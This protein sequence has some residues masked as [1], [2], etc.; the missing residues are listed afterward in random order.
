MDLCWLENK[1]KNT[2]IIE[3]KAQAKK[4]D[5]YLRLSGIASMSWLVYNPHPE[6][7]D[8]GSACFD[9]MDN[10]FDDL[11]DA[12]DMCEEG[13]DSAYFT[14]GTELFQGKMVSVS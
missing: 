9:G 11:E 13:I 12:N 14:L 2:V 1:H 5:E 3:S 7:L 6:S 10:N 4:F 8:S